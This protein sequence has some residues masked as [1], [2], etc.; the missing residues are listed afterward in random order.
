V[1]LHP[2]GWI[3]RDPAHP[4]KSAVI[5]AQLLATHNFAHKD[6]NSQQFGELIDSINHAIIPATPKHAK[7]NGHADERFVHDNNK[8]PD[9]LKQLHHVFGGNTTAAMILKIVLLHQS[10]DFLPEYQPGSPLTDDEIVDL[11]DPHLLR[12][13]R[14]LTQVDSASYSMCDKESL[15][16]NMKIIKSTEERLQRLIQERKGRSS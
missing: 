1:R 16:R 7:G 4:F 8:L 9:I 14:M 5:V 13:L 3:I 2:D 10:I 12:M 11:I 15:Y 6:Y